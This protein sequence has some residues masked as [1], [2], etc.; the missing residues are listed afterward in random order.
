MAEQTDIHGTLGIEEVFK[1]N[2]VN[3]VLREVLVGIG[4]G[5]VIAADHD[6]EAVVEERFR[7]LVGI[8]HRLRGIAVDSA[9]VLVD[10]K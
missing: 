7:H 2:I 8:T 9:V 1:R 3:Q 4:M 10:T 5:R 6:F